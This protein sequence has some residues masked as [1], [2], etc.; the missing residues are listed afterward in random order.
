MIPKFRAYDK[1]LKLIRD[2]QYVDF[3]FKEVMFYAD[4]YDEEN[5]SPS[6][7]IV[8]KFEEVEI[9][10]SAGFIDKNGI[11][12]FEGDIINLHW[13]YF[14]DGEESETQL[15][16][17]EILDRKG[18]PGFEWQDDYFPLVAGRWHEESFE[19]IGNVYE[20]PELLEVK[21]EK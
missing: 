2:I 7:E 1:H 20:N 15:Y 9:M 17:K 11:E 6:L 14:V 19:V 16:C 18:V 3:R 21:N 10:R 13:F 4:D 5:H 8:R 12:V